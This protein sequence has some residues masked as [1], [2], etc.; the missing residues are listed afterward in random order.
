M[1]NWKLAAGILTAAIALSPGAASAAA[2]SVI[3]LNY[4]ETSL[5]S[6]QVVTA[7][8]TLVPLQQLAQ[9]MGYALTWNQSTKSAKLI[10]PGREVT[11]TAGTVSAAVN[12][13]ASTLVKAPRILKGKVY[14]PLVSAVSLLGGKTV[15]DKGTGSLNI[16]DELRYSVASAQGRTYWV[17]QK[18]G[19]VFYSA[20][21]SGKPVL[22]GELPFADLTYTHSLEAKNVGKGTELL[23]LTDN[24]YAMFY[25]FSN[26]YQVLIKDGKV[27]KQMDYHYMTKSY[28]K[29]PLLKTDQLYMTDGGSV[30]YISADGSP[31]KLFDLENITGTEGTYTIEYAAEDIILVRLITNTQLYAIHTASRAGINLSEQLISAEDRKEWDRADGSDEFYLTKMLVLKKREGNVMTFTYATL[32]DGKVKTV[33][34]SVDSQ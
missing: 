10:R 32:P 15:Y 2:G 13:A 27:V 8:T 25:D 5:G 18:N 26:S 29:A 21:A 20:S 23:L 28:I 6:S 22:I 11:M 7:G 4:K 3:Q 31:G 24:H 16:V 34:Y 30:Q 12:G 9:T 14:V 33:T 19:D 1:R 17:S